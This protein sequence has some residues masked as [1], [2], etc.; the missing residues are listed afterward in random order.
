MK[1][2]LLLSFH[3]HHLFIP[4][5]WLEDRLRTVFKARGDKGNLG[6]QEFCNL[7]FENLVSN[8]ADDEI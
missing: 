3:H 6:Q 7:V 1:F 2:Y 8:Q 5:I 4:K